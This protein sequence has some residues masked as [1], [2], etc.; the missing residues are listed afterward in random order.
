M[1]VIFEMGRALASIRRLCGSNHEWYR[2]YK[3]L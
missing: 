2:H 3:L 1:P